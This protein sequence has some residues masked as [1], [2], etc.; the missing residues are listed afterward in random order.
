MTPKSKETTN[1]YA[2]MLRCADGTIYSGYTTA[3]TRRTAVHNSGRGAKYTRSRL[4]VKLVF[5]EHFSTKSEALKREAA[6][7]RLSHA[8]KLSLIKQSAYLIK[9]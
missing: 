9:E 4:P 5:T 6:L 3:P 7:K 8:D 1:Y 2:Y